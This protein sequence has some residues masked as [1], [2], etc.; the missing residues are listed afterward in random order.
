MDDQATRFVEQL[1]QNPAMLQKLL[2]SPDGQALMQMLNQGNQGAK[3]RNAVKDASKGNP[4]E[5]VK[6]VNQFIQTPDGAA[7]AERIQKM[8]GN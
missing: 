2:R 8:F 4:A 3:L 7:L 1:K 5:A 6:M